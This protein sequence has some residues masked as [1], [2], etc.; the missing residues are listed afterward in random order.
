MAS[1]RKP[2]WG[3]LGLLALLCAAGPAVAEPPA[4]LP[5]PRPVPPAEAPPAPPGPAMPTWLPRYD[6]DIRLDVAG[7][8][9]VVRQRVTWLNRHPLP[10]DEL[11]FNAHS[12]YTVPKNEVGLLAKTLEIMR[13]MPGE[14]LFGDVP[15]LEVTGV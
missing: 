13:M 5:P 12:H 2:A 7:H 10:A 4:E 9:A 1:P 14:A 15:A 8:T 6:V 11:V 3:L